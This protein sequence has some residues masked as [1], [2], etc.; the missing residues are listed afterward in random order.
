[1]STKM[2]EGTKVWMYP[3]IRRKYHKPITSQIN[4]DIWFDPDGM[5]LFYQCH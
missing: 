3:N 4:A 2:S 1:M 5:F